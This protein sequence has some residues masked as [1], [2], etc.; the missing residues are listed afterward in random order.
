MT[1]VMLFIKKK[2]FSLF[3]KKNLEITK[4]KLVWRSVIRNLKSIISFILNF[5]KF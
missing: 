2:L 3:I 4:L 5:G 1:C